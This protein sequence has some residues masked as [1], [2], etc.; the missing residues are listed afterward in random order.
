MSVA[1]GD[2][3]SILSLQGELTITCVGHLFKFLMKEFKD[4]LSLSNIFDVTSEKNSNLQSYN[5]SKMKF[6]N[7]YFVN[8][9]FN[10][11]MLLVHVELGNLYCKQQNHDGRA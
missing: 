5:V 3:A 9:F 7:V 10:F 1:T 8:I 4:A 6:P 11:T 2:Q